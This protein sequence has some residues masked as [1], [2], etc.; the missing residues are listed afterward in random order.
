MKTPKPYVWA[1]AILAIAFS[2]PARS[3]EAWLCEYAN[4]RHTGTV[5]SGF[6]AEGDR[7]IENSGDVISSYHLLED[8]KTAIVATKGGSY[9]SDPWVMGFLLMIRKETGQFALITA[10]IGS[11]TV[12]QTGKC[13][14]SG[15]QN[16]N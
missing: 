8:S 9:A 13:H 5:Q 16:L 4:Y 12:K 1:A 14:L 3:A 6:Q 10:P 2:N 15:G 7:L 11:E